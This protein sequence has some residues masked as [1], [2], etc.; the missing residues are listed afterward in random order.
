[1]RIEG[2]K[3]RVPEAL[4]SCETLWPTLAR[5]LEGRVT[6]LPLEDEAGSFLSL[7]PLTRQGNLPWLYLESD[8]GYAPHRQ[9]CA[10]GGETRAVGTRFPMVLIFAA[11]SEAAEVAEGAGLLRAWLSVQHGRFEASRPLLV[12]YG[13]R[14][15]SLS[16][17]GSAAALAAGLVR[18]GLDVVELHGVPQAAEYVVQCVAAVAESRKRRVPSRFK[19]AGMRCQTLRDPSDK[20]RISWVSQLMQIP[21]VSEDIAKII[22]EQF[23]SPGVLLDAVARAEQAARSDASSSTSAAFLDPVVA[24]AFIGELEYPIR[25][26]K[27]TRRIG[28]II[29][30]RVFTLFH[31]NVTPE[32][33]LV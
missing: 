15:A 3:V 20:L 26:K 33:V 31:A 17:A 29:S 11:A 21:G 28:P 14:P 22:A 7:P 13:A 9:I 19:V 4:R 8:F 23:P 32:L 6:W 27:S 12:A 2:V 1:M 30:R 25:G 18:H 24:D 10:E 16:S 5:A